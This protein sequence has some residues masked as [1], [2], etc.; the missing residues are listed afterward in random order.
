VPYRGAKI[1]SSQP[2]LLRDLATGLNTTMFGC[3]APP[4]CSPAAAVA[5]GSRCCTRRRVTCGLVVIAIPVVRKA[6]AA[7]GPPAPE[8][9]DSSVRWARTTA[10]R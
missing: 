5:F 2:G 6:T 9:K 3:A 1:M 7:L 10:Q 8:L 4:G